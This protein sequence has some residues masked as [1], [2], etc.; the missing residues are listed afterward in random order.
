MHLQSLLKGFKMLFNDIKPQIKPLQ[1]S[2]ISH[3]YSLFLSAKQADAFDKKRAQDNFILYAPTDNWQTWSAT[4]IATL[5]AENR[6]P[7]YYNFLQLYVEGNAG[8]FFLN[9]VDPHF[10]DRGGDGIETKNALE[11]LSHAWYSDKEHFD[12][13]ASYLSSIVNGCIYR[14][15]EEI[16]IARTQEEPRGRIYFESLSPISVLFDPTNLT[17]DIARGSKE[18]W[19]TFYLFPRDIASFFEWVRPELRFKLN[20]MAKNTQTEQYPTRNSEYPTEELWD[21]MYQIVEHYHIKKEYKYIAYDSAHNVQLP[22]SGYKFGSME[23]YLSK[24]SWAKSQGYN[25]QPE[26]I[27][28]IKVPTNVLYV[29]TF[30][31]QLGLLLENRRDERQIVDSKGN[32]KLPFFTWSYIT[33]NGKSIGLIDLGKDMQNDINERESAK[34][35]ILTQTQI[36]GKTI[37]HPE[38]FGGSVQKEQEFKENYTD[39]SKPFILDSNAPMNIDMLIKNVSG[40]TLNPAIL[41]D[42]N[43]KISM[44]DR[45]LR[46]PPAMQG[47]QGKSG[48]S[49]ILFG[50]Q[51]IEGNVLQKV[52][53][54]TLEQYQNYKFEARMALAIKLYGGETKTE[55][56]SNY[57]RKFSLSNGTTKIANEFVGVD[58]NGNDIVVNDLSKLTRA[59]V[60]VSQSKDNDYMKQAKR[61]VDIAYLGAMPET[62]TNA[63]YRAIAEADLAKNMDGVTQEQEKDIEEMAQLSIEIAKKNLVLQSAGLD[64]QLQQLQ[65]AQQELNNTQPQQAQGGNASSGNYEDIE[66]QP[67]SMQ[68]GEAERVQINPNRL[69]TT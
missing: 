18:A 25:L 13:S 20:A 55:K 46:L 49:G 31:P 45:I 62:A 7:N 42:E 36:H 9:K 8:N 66:V 58:D 43:S 67:N 19:K 37:A 53:A 24:V 29:T 61:E 57:D 27:K 10:V 50:R 22:D 2:E 5:K 48:T 40:N 3:E 65:M 51:V 39:A 32:T 23:D 4:N 12:Y 34:T 41:Q 1:S 56:M 14:G 26:D 33:K 17:D 11:V 21:Q 69:G 15:V 28:E 30:C 54:S 47:L 38:A 68:S 59:S 64:Q 35:K 63:G 44:M 6:P 52:P 16:K 60:I